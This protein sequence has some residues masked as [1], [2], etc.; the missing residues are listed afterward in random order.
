MQIDA[1]LQM[2]SGCQSGV[3][4]DW[5]CTSHEV[6]HEVFHVH[7]ECFAS[8]HMCQST[9]CMPGSHSGQRRVPDLLE[10]ELALIVSLSVDGGNQTCVS[11][12]AAIALTPELALQEPFLGCLLLLCCTL[13]IADLELIDCIMPFSSADH[14]GFQK[15]LHL[16][17][18]LL[19][20]PVGCYM[21]R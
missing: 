20:S 21:G 16:L 18:P 13:S 12:R 19:L 15:R 2:R 11:A 17:K 8:L 6:R 9:V 7:D 3:A 1:P 14:S 5:H 4:G 10:L